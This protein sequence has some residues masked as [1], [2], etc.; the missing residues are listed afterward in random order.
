MPPES[1]AFI[2][3][4]GPQSEFPLTPEQDPLIGTPRLLCE[5]LAAHAAIVHG[6][7]LSGL[8]GQG[9]GLGPGFM[10]HMNQRSC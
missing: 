4:V 3:T 8:C 10:A 6:F 1:C 2:F 9:S 5:A 7:D